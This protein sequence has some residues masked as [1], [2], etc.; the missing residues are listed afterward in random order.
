MPLRHEV[1]SLYLDMVSQR[2]YL[3][4]R[5]IIKP[6]CALAIRVARLDCRAIT[7]LDHQRNNSEEWETSKCLPGTAFSASKLAIVTKSP[8]NEGK[9]YLT[10]F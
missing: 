4:C 1:K 8:S 6:S 9:L 7:D 2:I 10:T 5:E 3:H